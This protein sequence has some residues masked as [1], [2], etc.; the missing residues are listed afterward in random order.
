MVQQ[1]ALFHYC[2]SLLSGRLPHV[3]YKILCLLPPSCGSEM[4][5]DRP[6]LSKTM[7]LKPYSCFKAGFV[8]TGPAPSALGRFLLTHCFGAVGR[9]R[10]ECR[11]QEFIQHIWPSIWSCLSHRGGHLTPRHHEETQADICILRKEGSQAI[12]NQKCFVWQI[13]VTGK[14]L[15]RVSSTK[16]SLIYT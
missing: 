14:T 3:S 10:G 9:P 2:L 7:Y 1:H 4:A 13:W 11:K 6:T 8:G 15:K 16:S 12:S 5:T